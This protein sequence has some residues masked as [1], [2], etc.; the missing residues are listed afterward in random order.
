MRRGASYNDIAAQSTRTKTRTKGCMWV[1]KIP[2][3]TKEA[4]RDGVVRV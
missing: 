3:M 4:E 2:H 1:A